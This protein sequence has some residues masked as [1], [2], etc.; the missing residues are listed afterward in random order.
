MSIKHL[1]RS[2]SGSQTRFAYRFAQAGRIF[3][4][5]LFV[6]IF[7]PESRATV[8]DIRSAGDTSIRQTSEILPKAIVGSPYR[9]PVRVWGGSPPFQFMMAQ[10]ELPAGLSLNSSSG[11][12]SGTPSVAGSYQFVVTVNDK[13]QA[14]AI[15]VSLWVANAPAPPPPPAVPAIPAT[16]FGIHVNHT[17]TP[18][19][20]VPVGSV[21]MWDDE[22]SWA[23][24]NTAPGVF[25]WT[26]FDSRVEM[27]LGA[28]ADILYDLARTPGWAQCA[29][30]DASC[31]SANPTITCNYAGL[32]GEGGPGQCFPP[33]D[34]K[35][36]G[37]G[38]NQ[39]WIDWV[40]AVAARYKGRIKF[41]EIWNE[42]SIPAMWQGTNAQLVRMTQDARCI[43]VGTG[44]N[45]QSNYT[46]TGIDPSAHITSPGFV[47][48]P[49]MHL[50]TALDNYLKAG[51]GTYVDVIAFHAYVGYS[52]DQ[53]ELVVTQADSVK[54]VALT[55]GQ[56]GKPVF[57]TEGSWGGR[58]VISDPDQ[59]AA[60]LSRYLILQ[61]SSGL[62]R[63]Y[64]YSWDGAATPLWSQSAGTEVGGTTYGEVS[65]WLVGASLTS[66][67][68]ANGSVWTCAY[69]R[70]GGYKALAVWDA[71]Q[72]CSSGNC[73]TS[74]FNV[75]S[76]YV[77]S[78]DLAGIKTR[79]GGST[80]QIG[81]KPILLENQ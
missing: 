38:A 29:N 43:I 26:T 56:Q 34:L 78:R 60:W 28:N 24:V 41:Y 17:H 71:S 7:V 37:S 12:I 72:T 57:N 14:A 70:P 36:D 20:N 44:C 49:A 45:S 35:V 50:T 33:N 58:T 21:R 23:Q 18:M 51:G 22:T 66:P 73:T 42:P 39:H 9:A 1:L 15:T 52:P 77:Y 40:T 32:A 16:F 74:T 59:Q 54:S 19:P 30:N 64:W 76:G 79:I 2:Q 75:P 13:N 80:V 25:D 63:S 67:C 6:L 47:A 61:Q 4:T 11:V 27:A 48:A 68:A 3:L 5:I 65:N 46:Q 69:T 10:G 8:A 31:G 55:N 81:S 53:P 62:A